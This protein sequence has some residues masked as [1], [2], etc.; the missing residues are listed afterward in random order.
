VC[1]FHGSEEKLE[2]AEGWI[3]CWFLSSAV[4][5]RNTDMRAVDLA[6]RL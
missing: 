6:D 1:K 3:Q 5:L 2:E 4:V